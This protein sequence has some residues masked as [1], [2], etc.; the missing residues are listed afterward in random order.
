MSRNGGGYQQR[1]QR[2]PKRPEISQKN[3]KPL[4]KPPELQQSDFHLNENASLAQDQSQDYTLPGEIFTVNVGPPI[5]D[6]AGFDDGDGSGEFVQVIV[7]IRPMLQFE[8]SRGD[9]YCIKVL[10]SQNMQL[11]KG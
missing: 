8:I 1:Y 5:P 6:H 3:L 7:R 2:L 10:D 9:D 11:N 4:P